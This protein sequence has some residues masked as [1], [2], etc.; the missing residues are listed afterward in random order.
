VATTCSYKHNGKAVVSYSASAQWKAKWLDNNNQEI[1]THVNISANDTLRNMKAGIYKVIIFD[2]N[3]ICQNLSD[4]V[5]IDSASVINPN[6]LVSNN[7]CK[8]DHNGSISLSVNGG[9]APYQYNWSNGVNSSSVQ[10]LSSGIYT[11]VITDA[12]GCRDTTRHRIN[13]LS[14]LQA[15]FSIQND[16]GTIYVNDLVLFKNEASG[17][18]AVSW[19][20]GNGT[21]GNFDPSHT[22][23]EAGKYTVSLTCYDA[24]CV[25]SCQKSIRVIDQTKPSIAEAGEINVYQNE[26]QAV[27]QFDMTQPSAG[28]ITVYSSDGKLIS[29][30][31]TEAF[32][33]KESVA[34]GASHGMYIVRV[35]TNGN[36]YQEKLLK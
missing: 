17:A 23:S 6:A 22:F 4:N 16:T 9:L 12:N 34:L 26:D 11:L 1:T 13:T 35:E 31:K 36:I 19:D 27:V 30:M 18:V 3:A 24:W 21:S 33:N 2:N 14:N 5:T 32:K 15:Q 10:N 20:F 8:Y 28:I 25:S 7:N 29:S